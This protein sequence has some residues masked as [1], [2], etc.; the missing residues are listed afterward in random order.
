[1]LFVVASL[2]ISMFYLERQFLQGHTLQAEVFLEQ[3]ALTE[4]Q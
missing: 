3:K 4:K 1:M 2:P